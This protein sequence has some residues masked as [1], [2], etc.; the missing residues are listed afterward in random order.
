MTRFPSYSWMNTIPLYIQHV[1]HS[2]IVGTQIW[3][4]IL[5]IMNNTAMSMRMHVSPW[6]TDF[7]SF[8]IDLEVG[9]LSYVVVLFFF[10]EISFQFPFPS[11]VHRV[12]FLPHSGQHLFSVVFL[13]KATLVYVRWHHIVILIC[14]S[15]MISDA[16]Y[17]FM[18]LLVLTCSLWKKVYSGPWSIF[19]SGFLKIKLY[20]FLTHYGY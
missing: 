1:I 14:I 13:I 5:V 18:N 6:D 10:E 7:V 3:F 12:L 2:S 9:F 8:R 15:L 17:L 20:K 19:W 11:T 16:K 4:Q